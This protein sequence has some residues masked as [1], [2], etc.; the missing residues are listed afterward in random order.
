MK[1]YYKMDKLKQLIIIGGGTSLKEGEMK[2]L[3]N[4]LKGKW[5][6]GLN[7]NYNYFNS[8]ILCFVDDDF[9]IKQKKDIAKLNL[10]IGKKHKL[11]DIAPNT[12]MLSCLDSKYD[13]SLISGVY[14]SSLLGIF[15]LSLGIYL[16]DK[17]EIYL[18]GYDYGSNGTKDK[19]GR[20]M[21]HS[22]QGEINHRGIGKT[23][24]YDM[25]GRAD[26]DFGVYRNEKKV[27]IYNVSMK[28]R[29]NIFPKIS[30]DE[31]FKKLDKKQYNQDKLRQHIK[32]KLKGLK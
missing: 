2:E 12:M 31:F 19:Q 5:T 27:K 18:L 30:Y 6:I 28:S 14:K 13:R 21:T 25:K 24:Y 7:Y 22:Y 3:Y 29:I 23:N 4:K 15:A 16:L 26:K 10:I 32:E 17:G 8:T 9:Y 20:P 1:E 11:K